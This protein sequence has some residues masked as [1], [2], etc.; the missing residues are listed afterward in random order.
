MRKKVPG[1]IINGS[2]L[3]FARELPDPA[4]PEEGR[5]MKLG[6]PA[7]GTGLPA[8]ASKTL[9]PVGLKPQWVNRIHGGSSICHRMHCFVARYPGSPCSVGLN[10]DP[11][12]SVKAVGVLRPPP[13][14][15]RESTD[16]LALLANVP[17]S[18]LV[19]MISIPPL[20]RS[21][22]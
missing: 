10:E 11:D 20:D 2:K 17:V 21:G 15:K 5:I 1:P 9:E 12:N 4:V 3:L 18:V 19:K 6:L 16:R 7:P 14:V 8:V 22:I 13:T